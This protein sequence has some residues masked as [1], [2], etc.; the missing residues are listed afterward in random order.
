LNTTLAHWLT[1]LPACVAF[2]SAL[3]QLAARSGWRRWLATG[4]SVA[5]LAVPWLAPRGPVLRA[6]LTL[7]L[8]W[9]CAKV[10]DITRDSQ[11]RSALFRWIW[12]LVL[13]DLRRDGYARAGA[14]PV[15]QPKLLL[16]AVLWI[17]IAVGALHLALFEASGLALLPHALARLGAGLVACYFGVEG[18][19]RAFEFFYRCF[20]LA[21]PTLHDH[22]ILSLSLAEFWGRRWNRVVG[23][24]L[25]RTFYR[26]LA[27][28]GQRVLSAAA[29]F[30]ASALLHFYFTWLA[31][32]LR[33]SL[34]MAAF[35]L[36]Q[37][38]LTLLEPALGQ[39]RWPRPLRHLWTAGCL[40]VTSPLF[41]A[42]TL[43]TLE[44]G[45]R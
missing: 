18:A 31:L 11:P 14:R 29:T 42:P 37:V 15:L 1:W 38:P 28:R 33:W 36:L 32:G 17:G 21:P 30:G 40:L 7:Y 45:F 27:L 44:G 41:V 20:G 23:Y 8:L 10:I 16:G 4:L 22:P 13:H 5:A 35:F 26:P 39:A 19:L 6:T 43:L 2:A 9:T 24:W 25:F 12:M 3:S 34:P